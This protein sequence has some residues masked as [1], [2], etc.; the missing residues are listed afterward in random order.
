MVLATIAVPA[1]VAI[2]ILVSPLLSQALLIFEIIPQLN[3][4]HKRLVFQVLLSSKPKHS[5]SYKI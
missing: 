5:H 2:L 4:L 3:Y 1:E